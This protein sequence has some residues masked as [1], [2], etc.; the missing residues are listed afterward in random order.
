MIESKQLNWRRSQKGHT[1]H[2]E[3]RATALLHVVPDQTYAGMWRIQSA[4]GSLSDMANLTRAKDAALAMELG[5]LNREIRHR[6]RPAEG[7][8]SDLNR[9][10]DAGISSPI[11]AQA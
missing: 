5:R 3:R 7:V 6:Q 11:E 8:Y 10:H 2:L 9:K 1:L 4:D